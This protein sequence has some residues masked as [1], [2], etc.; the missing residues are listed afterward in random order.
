[1]IFSQSCYKTEQELIDACVRQE[2]KAQRILYESLAPRMFSLCRR[3]VSDGESAND[4]LQ[5]GFITLFTRIRSFNGEGSFEGW[6]RKIFVNTALMYLRKNDI[7]KETLNVDE[8]YSMTPLVDN[9]M[10]KL[11]GKD[12]LKL[13]SEMPVGYRAVFNLGVFEGYSHQEIS[14]ILNISEGASRSQ[15]S[16]ARGWLQ[17]KIEKMKILEK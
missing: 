11:E 6:A 4:L 9:V 1:M 15:L 3:Y 17:D 14:Q 5:E 7:M 2:R 13:I 12:V 10:E 8:L 16:R